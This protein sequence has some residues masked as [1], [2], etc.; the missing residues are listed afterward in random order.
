[1]C[2]ILSTDSLDDAFVPETPSNTEH[3]AER[4]APTGTDVKPDYSPTSMNERLLK[5]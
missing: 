4:R 5:C 2:L 1:M 3:A